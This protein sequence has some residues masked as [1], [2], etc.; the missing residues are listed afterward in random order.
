MLSSYLTNFKLDSSWLSLLDLWQELYAS[1]KN[2]RAIKYV[3]ILFLR[4]A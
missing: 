3:L 4:G 1:V 2:I